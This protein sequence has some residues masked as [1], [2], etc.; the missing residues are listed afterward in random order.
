MPMSA[1]M[2]IQ[3]LR[4]GQR[5]LSHGPLVPRLWQAMRDEWQRRLD[6]AA[7]QSVRELGHEGVLEDYRMACRFTHR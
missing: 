5:R 6:R 1:S 4:A 2:S 7:A 3:T